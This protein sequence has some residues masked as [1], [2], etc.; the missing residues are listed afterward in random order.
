MVN[1]IKHY[2]FK[3][4]RQSRPK[5]TFSQEK[6]SEYILAVSDAPETFGYTISG[7][8]QSLSIDQWSGRVQLKWNKIHKLSGSVSLSKKMKI[9]ILAMLVVW[10]YFL[11][12][13]DLP[14]FFA[15]NSWG[16]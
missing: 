16:P 13:S 5:W 12:I 15:S 1:L 2:S 9:D 4:P 8:Y 3:Y 6:W 7:L 11:A 14:E 10:M